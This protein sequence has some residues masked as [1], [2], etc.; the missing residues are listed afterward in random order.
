MSDLKHQKLKEILNKL[1]KGLESKDKF[2]EV[3]NKL[4]EIYQGDFRHSYSIITAYILKDISEENKDEVLTNIC[5]NL[6]LIID[7][8]SKE[9]PFLDRIKKL[10]DHINLEA[11]RLS[12]Y[13]VQISELGKSLS[14]EKDIL[15]QLEKQNEKIKSDLKNQQT[16]YIVILGIFASIVLAF[17]GSFTFSTSVFANIDKS[18]IYKLVL[19]MAFI[20][21]FITNI[22]YYLFSFIKDIGFQRN[23][24]RSKGGI[25]LFNVLIIA[26]LLSDLIIYLV[27]H[28]FNLQ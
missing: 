25:V 24:G 14:Q 16:Q 4:E 7:Q 8:I 15:E 6:N 21:C 18:S 28:H 9:N 11:N 23:T 2:K 26:I 5:E 13:R 19:V 12:Y 10:Q 1:S 27:F 17:V 22:L 3:Q 20:A